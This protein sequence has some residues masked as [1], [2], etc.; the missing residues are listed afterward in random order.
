MRIRTSI[1]SALTEAARVVYDELR[2]SQNMR[3]ALTGAHKLRQVHFESNPTEIDPLLSVEFVNNFATAFVDGIQKVES[4]DV[5]TLF[6]KV[7]LAEAIR[8]GIRMSEKFH[9]AAVLDLSGK[10]F[11]ENQ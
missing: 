7:M 9:N 5:A 8:F 6:T 3:D 10:P 1:E 2:G 11:R 4:K